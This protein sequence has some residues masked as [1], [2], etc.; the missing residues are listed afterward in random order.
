MK[1]NWGHGIALFI[2]AFVGFIIFMVAKAFQTSTDLTAENYYSQE[3][4]YG[5]RIDAISNAAKLK[6]PM[7]LSMEDDQVVLEL[8]A[9]LMEQ[10]GIQGEIHFYRPDNAELDYKQRLN[11]KPALQYIP[12]SKLIS[13]NYSVR[14]LVKGENKTFYFEQNLTFTNK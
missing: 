8:P 11:P 2:L 12:H 7:T 4:A 5:E 9:D 10:K 1:F 3:L 14:V 6:Q 13:G